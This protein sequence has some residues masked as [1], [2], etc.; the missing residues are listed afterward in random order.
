MESNKQSKDEAANGAIS[1][2]ALQA[3]TK[4]LAFTIRKEI[5]EALHRKMTGPHVYFNCDY[6]GCCTEIKQLG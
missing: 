2:T 5:T 6:L 3:A 1:Y 4:T